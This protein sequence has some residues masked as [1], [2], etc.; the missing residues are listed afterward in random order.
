MFRRFTQQ[1]LVSD[2]PDNSDKCDLDTIKKHTAFIEFTP[3]GTILDASDI[4]LKVVGYSLSEI[5]GQKHRIFCKADYGNSK[6]YQAFWAS[7]AQGDAQSGTFHRVAKN[8]DCVWLEANYFPIVENSVVKKVIKIASDVTQNYLSLQNK[9]SLFDALDRSSA[10]IEFTPEGHVIT[11]NSNFLSTIGYRLEDI[12]GKHHRMFCFENFY[13]ENPTFWTKLAA[14]SFESGRFERKNANGESIWLEATYNP[15]KDT[16]GN[17]SK[18]IK[19]ASDIT[20]SIQNSQRAIEAAS[21]T[22]EETSQITT[23][24]RQILSETLENS[25]HISTQI[26]EASELTDKLNEQS[27]KIADTVSIISSIADQ[28]NLLALNAAIEAARAGEQGRGFAVV[29]DEVR[30][31]AAR[32]SEATVGITSTVEA[33]KHLTENIRTQMERIRQSSEGGQDKINHLNASMD[34]VVTGVENFALLVT[35]LDKR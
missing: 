6:E 26:T 16:N 13:S 15:V 27:E 20:Q 24:A 17:V 25:T 5:K 12:Q 19:F 3:D 35:E 18:I 11:A 8:G 4:F 30:T 28:T 23:E 32:T 1:P 29:A 21:A 22:S 7:L 34:E 31:L 2:Q 9:N 33:N 10:V 14:G